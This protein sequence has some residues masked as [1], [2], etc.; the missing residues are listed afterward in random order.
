MTAVFSSFVFCHAARP[1]SPSSQC[2]R[3][4]DR[5]D[6]RVRQ[7]LPVSGRPARGQRVLVARR[8]SSPP[9]SAGTISRSRRAA[10]PLQPA[11]PSRRAPSGR[12][13]GRLPQP[14]HPRGLREGRLLVKNPPS[15]RLRRHDRR[16]SGLRAHRPGDPAVTLVGD[17]SHPPRET[18]RWRRL[19]G[20]RTRRNGGR[21]RLASEFLVPFGRAL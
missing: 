17:Y 11:C 10:F 9:S 1:S 2:S 18:L 3:V 12:H 6:P 14:E 4:P 15:A 16:S 19:P 21:F 8:H 5:R 20:R 13:E 7:I